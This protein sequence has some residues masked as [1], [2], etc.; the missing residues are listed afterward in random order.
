M[1]ST[2]RTWVI[3]ICLFSGIAIGET[4]S[5]DEHAAILNHAIAELDDVN[6]RNWAFTETSLDSDG[7]FVGR[8]DPSLPAEE[9]WTLLTINGRSPTDAECMDYTA[10]KAHDGMSDDE[11][12]D[13]NDIVEPGSLRLLEETEEFL[14][15]SFI[16]I[17]DEDDDGFFEHVVTRLQFGPVAK[18]GPIGPQSIDININVRAFLI[19][20]VNESVEIRYSDYEYVGG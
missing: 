16:P 5:T 18:D 17:E 20:T 8:F 11:D 12:N 4:V 10:N 19:K 15:F 2:A 13:V 14:L 9:G 7:E 1:G 6:R 3:S